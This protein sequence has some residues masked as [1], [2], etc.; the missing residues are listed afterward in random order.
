MTMN[1]AASGATNGQA[2]LVVTD[3]CDRVLDPV[4]RASEVLFGLIMVLTVTLSVGVGDG[5]REGIRLVLIGALGCN[6]A[7]GIIDAVMYLMGLWGERSLAAATILAIRQTENPAV[8]RSIVARHLPPIVLPAL[9]AADL[10]RIRLHLSSLPPDSVGR[11]SKGRICLA[12]SAC[13][14]SSSSACFLWLPR[15]WLLRRPASH[16]G[17]RTPSP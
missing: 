9:T 7:W 3:R 17:S 2:P 14:Y 1:E 10:E 13:F 15:S 4:E 6:L 12:H 5:S 16:C 11:G 8:G